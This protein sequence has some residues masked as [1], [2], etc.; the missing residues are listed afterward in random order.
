MP[1]RRGAQGTG[2]ADGTPGATRTKKDGL[3]ERVRARQWE[4]QDEGTPERWLLFRG[5]W[6]DYRRGCKLEIQLAS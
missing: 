3:E 2:G 1:Q 4:G 5:P 6:F